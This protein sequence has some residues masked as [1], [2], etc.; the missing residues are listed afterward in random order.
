MI[1]TIDTEIRLSGDA[2]REFYDQMRSVDMNAI[3]SRDAFLADVNCR[4]DEEGTLIIYDEE[5]AEEH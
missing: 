3:A 4:L 1:V 2:A 5:S